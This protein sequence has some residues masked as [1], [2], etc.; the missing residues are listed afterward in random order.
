MFEM[1]GLR[2]KRRVHVQTNRFTFKST[3][4]RLNQRAQFKATGS[5]SN[6]QACVQS[7]RLMFEVTG[8]CLNQQAHVQINRLTFEA[9]G[10]WALISA[11]GVHRRH[12]G[13]NAM[14]SSGGGHEGKR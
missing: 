10:L 14:L 2:S 1:P 8:S 7:D 3:G 5:R 13:P 9:T 4:S 11:G 12:V 6:Q